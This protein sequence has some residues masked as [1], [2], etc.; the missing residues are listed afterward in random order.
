MAITIH[1]LLGYEEYET[2]LEDITVFINNLFDF[3]F[4]STKIEEERSVYFYNEN[5][6]ID[7]IQVW[8]EME[9]YALANEIYLHVY[10]HTSKSIKSLYYDEDEVWI[11]NDD[12]GG[13]EYEENVTKL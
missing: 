7:D 3:E 5:L 8:S 1:A 11:D 9:E 13:D 10:D 12:M 6:S 4:T 2:R